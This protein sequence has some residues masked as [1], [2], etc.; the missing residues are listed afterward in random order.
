M[1]QILLRAQCPQ[2]LGDIPIA[3]NAIAMHVWYIREKGDKI[4]KS[5]E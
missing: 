3:Q 4:R 2:V 5:K 1:L